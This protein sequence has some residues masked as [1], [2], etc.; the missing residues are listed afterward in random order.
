[1]Q[2]ALCPINGQGYYD[3]GS[4]NQGFFLQQKVRKHLQPDS[5][6]PSRNMHI[7]N[8]IRCCCCC[9]CARWWLGV[10]AG[11]G[12]QSLNGRFIGSGHFPPGGAFERASPGGRLA[13]GLW[14]S[15]ADPAPGR[16]VPFS[17]ADPWWGS[18][19][20]T[21]LRVWLVPFRPSRTVNSF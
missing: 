15:S 1:M 9:C 3:V 18:G 10:G 17:V 13:A 6:T 12:R 8:R 16:P 7:H 11:R 14:S 4:I 21:L 19:P 2:K 20:S 5:P